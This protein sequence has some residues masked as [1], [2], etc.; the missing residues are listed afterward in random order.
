MHNSTSYLLSVLRIRE[1]QISRNPYYVSLWCCVFQYSMNNQPVTSHS[2]SYRIQ[3]Q[4]CISIT[5]AEEQHIIRIRGQAS[6]LNPLST[7]FVVQHSFSVVFH[8][9]YSHIYNAKNFNTKHVTICH[10]MII[11]N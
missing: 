11:R 3:D 2:V 7:F 6:A 9:C 10:I 1:V 8:K 5:T 4:F